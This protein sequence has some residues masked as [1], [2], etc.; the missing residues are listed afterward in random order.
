VYA[1][2]GGEIGA[3][4]N[5][6]YESLVRVD[7]DDG[8]ETYFHVEPKTKLEVGDPVAA[9]DPLGSVHTSSTPHNDHIHFYVWR[10]YYFASSGHVNPLSI[11]VSP[12]PSFAGVFL[13]N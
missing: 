11:L 5:S 8:S 9:G 13:I 2:R 3:L 1:V 6:G 4:S 10:D 7:H 12:P